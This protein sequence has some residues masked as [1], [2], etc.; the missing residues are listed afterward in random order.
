VQSLS[1]LQF[2]ILAACS[3]LGWRKLNNEQLHNLYS[4][5]SIIIMIKSRRMKWAGLVARMREKN[6]CRS[7]V[8][9]PEGKR[10]LA[11]HRRM[12]DYYVKMDLR[13]GWYG[14]D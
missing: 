2:Y 1:R 13:M 5:P 11:A 9:K 6:A 3:L 8:G 14:L 12:R 10:P 7:L 4:L